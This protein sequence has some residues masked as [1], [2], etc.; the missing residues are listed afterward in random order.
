MSISVNESRTLYYMSK[1]KLNLQG[2]ET[3]ILI[4]CSSKSLKSLLLQLPSMTHT[5]ISVS[6]FKKQFNASEK[7][8]VHGFLIK[9]RSLS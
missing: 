5:F 2:F 7:R 8:Q 3:V 4:G 6:R 1:I 9:K